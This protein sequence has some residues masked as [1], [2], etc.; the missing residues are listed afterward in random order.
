[1]PLT[2]SE[3]KMF[4]PV[5]YVLGITFISGNYL[6]WFYDRSVDFGFI[7]Y[8]ILSLVIGFFTHRAYRRKDG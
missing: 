3:R 1:M 4:F 5:F 2:Q 6:L 7:F 8:G